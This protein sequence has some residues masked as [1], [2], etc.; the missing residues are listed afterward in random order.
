[1]RAIR[2]S[3][4]SFAVFVAIGS[5][6]T[7]ARAQQ[8]Q[9]VQ[10][11]ADALFNE[12]REL[13]EKAR[14][15][16]ACAKLKESEQLSPATGTLLNLGYCWEQL[17]RMRSAMEAYGEAEV[18]AAT[19]NDGKRIGMAKERY[20][21]AEKKAAKLVV[22]IAPQTTEDLVVTRNGTAMVKSDFDRPVPVDP[23]DF[24]IVAAAP[25][26]QTW[27]G[28]VIVRGDGAVVTVIVPPLVPNASAST[29]ATAS[30]SSL[31]SKRILAL[32]LGGV[33]AI[34][35]GAGIGTALSAKS[36]YNDARSH[37]DDTGCD[38]TGVAIQQG[39]AAQGN[40]ATLLFALGLASVGGGVYF[41]ITGAPDADGRSRGG[42]TAGVGGRF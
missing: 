21:A 12:G 9:H 41:W 18:L 10:Q 6:A 32:A 31:G 39:A 4:A 19:A 29:N 7:S 3:I 5:G 23:E 25:A 26:F 13:L 36:R 27:R 38:P 37:C 15:A 17:G 22:R 20:A 8:P 24:V 11:Q 42:A 34:F 14:F 28:A 2:S 40:V 1:M 16:E 30:S 33:G 35:L